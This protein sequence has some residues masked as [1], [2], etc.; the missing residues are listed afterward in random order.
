AAAAYRLAAREAQVTL[1][2]Q[3]EPGSGTSS[4]SFAWLNANNKAPAAYHALNVDGIAAHSRLGADLGGA[5][6]LHLTGNLRCA[7][8]AAAAEL[9][10]QVEALQTLAYP[11]QRIDRQRAQELEPQVRWPS[12]VDVAFTHFPQEG[13]ADGPLLVQTLVGAAQSLG[14]IVRAGDGVT[15]LE[16]A[17]DRATAVRLASGARLNADAVVLAAGRWSDRVA[18]LA[19]LR[20]PLAPTCGLLAITAPLLHGPRG[21]VHAPGVHFR[22]EGGG[23][24]V[25]QDDDTDALVEPAT[26][27]DPDLPACREL[28]RRAAAYLPELAGV[29]IVEARVGIRALPADGYSVV[30]FAPGVANLYLAVTHSGMTL[31]PLLGE[32][33]AAELLDGARDARLATFRPDRCVVPC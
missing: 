12:G 1:I 18:A 17:G 20:L 19:G 9:G 31:G 21:V 6:W 7:S 16:L 28:W 23:R 33:V 3:A 24:V 13:W 14:A 4:T 27:R 30:G 15:A 29:R 11:V 10:K 22:P 5:A 8:G 2:D 26:P 25:L 32:L